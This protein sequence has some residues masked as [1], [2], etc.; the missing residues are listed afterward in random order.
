[1]MGA[2]DMSIVNV[3]LPEMRA[4]FGVTL[5]EV[6][7]VATGYLVAVVV[8]LP[9]TSWLASVIGRKNLYL[10]A[11]VLFTASS[12]FCGMSHSL[13]ELLFFRGLQGLG[14]GLMQPIAQAVLREIFPPAEQAMAMG[15]FGIAILLGP[16]IGPTL[17]GWLTDNYGWPWVFFINIPIGVLAFLSASQLLYDP[18]Y[19]KR[20][21]VSDVDYQGIILL[22]VGLASLQTLLSEGQSK[23]W[24]DSM[25]IVV[26][27]AIAG[28]SLIA[29]VV[30]ELGAAKPAVDLSILT[31]PSYT[32]GTVLGGFLGLALFGGIFMLPQFMQGLLRYDALQSG[33]AMLPRSL[34]MMVGMPIAGRLYNH[35]G[36][37]FM[38][39]VGLALSAVASFQMGLFT[40]DTSYFGL[41]VPQAWQ[42]L[43][44]SFIFVSL[45]TAALAT[46]PRPRMTNATALY[47]LVRQLGGSFGI[48]IIATLLEKKQ[49]VAAAI[50]S[51]NLNPYNVAFSQ[52]YAL[53][54]KG[55]AAR[56]VAPDQAG[57]KA[58]A[59]LNGMVQQQSAVLAFQYVFIVIGLLFVATLPLAFFLRSRKETIP[60][61]SYKHEV[62]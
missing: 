41:V 26:L 43:A 49:N 55:L 40:A 36:P 57:S 61:V 12:F 35:L 50:L 21:R 17:G 4:S 20:Q 34:V 25:Y 15:V 11:V 31:N 33:I 46:V 29:F 62:D 54:A 24:F 16:A 60:A 37:R 27:A 30:W 1:M 42:G 9:L 22:T 39:G 14:A 10:F 5:T 56:G 18:P 7:W 13:A 23:E 8:V 51:K 28:V 32:S 3:A 45:S 38:V 48:A 52:R 53:I 59:L 58:L 19:L 2:I 47:N 44:F 6:S